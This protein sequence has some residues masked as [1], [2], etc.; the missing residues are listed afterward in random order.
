VTPGVPERDLRGLSR[1]RF[2]GSAGTVGAIGAAATISGA[3]LLAA[4]P[5]LAA[6]ADGNNVV[7]FAGTHQAGIVTPVQDRLLFAT[8]D[9]ITDDRAELVQM[10]RDWTTASRRMVLGQ[11]VGR[12][13]DDQD[14]PPD[15]TG[16]AIGLG[17]SSLTLTFGFGASLFTR[18]GDP[19][20]IAAKQPDA[21]FPMPLFARDEIQS[22]RSEGDLA[23]QSCADDP[24]VAFH[25][26]R[27]L[28]RIGRGVV[29][30][31]WSQL[32]FGRT[33]VTD[34]RQ[35]TPRNLMGFKD[36]TNNVVVEDTRALDEHVWVAPSDEPAWMR[37][38]SYLV[39]R[40][41]RMMLEIWDRSTL[42]DQELTIGRNKLEGAPL[43]AKLEHDS[44]NLA[45]KKD[46][47]LVIPE[48]AHIRLAAP[49]ENDGAKML[50]RG[51]SFTDGIDPVTNQLDAGLFFIAYQRDPRTGFIPVQENLARDTLNEYIR[52]D[53][54]GTFAC[55]PGVGASGYV[56]E[57]LFA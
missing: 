23:I 47:D 14:L 56:G 16:E 49:E 37:G 27:D 34:D 33:S 38:G 29:A 41:I 17:P 52:H 39:T 24:T 43:G 53:S 25:A 51:F 44:V 9:V 3:T 45:A 18:P 54:S 1:R 21:L 48:F 55:P 4:T 40:R 15:D 13:N 6:G 19:F 30:L 28:A 22:E 42:A 31:R 10:L 7:P 5:A 57:T 26:I 36:G 12:V 50:R 11:P 32:G 8:F 46:G 2:L 20:G 35:V